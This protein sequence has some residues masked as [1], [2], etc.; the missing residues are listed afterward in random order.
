MTVPQADPQN[1]QSHDEARDRAGGADVE[2]L[3]AVVH[4]GAQPDER[5]ECSNTEGRREARQEKR[6]GGIPLGKARR[7]VENG[8][9]HARTPGT[10]K[11]RISSSACKKKN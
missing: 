3:A 5:A 2:Q 10:V 4:D 1:R 8:K 7:G 6:R 9:G 11:N